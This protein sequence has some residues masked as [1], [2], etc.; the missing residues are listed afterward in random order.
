[1]NEWMDGWFASMD[2]FVHVCIN[3]HEHHWHLP[4][5]FCL[6]FGSYDGI[7][8]PFNKIIFYIIVK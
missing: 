2:L 3:S 5:F 6:F 4:C 8:T 7:Q 1:M